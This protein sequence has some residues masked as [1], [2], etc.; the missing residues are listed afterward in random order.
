MI[1]VDYYYRNKNGE[2]KEGTNEFTDREKARRFIIAVRKAKDK[3]LIGWR[4]DD[5]E[6]NNYIWQRT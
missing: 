4:C 2:T 3:T 1:Y 5:P 6:D